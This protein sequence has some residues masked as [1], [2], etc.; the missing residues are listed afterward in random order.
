ML[1]FEMVTAV[2]GTAAVLFVPAGVSAQTTDRPLTAAEERTVKPGAEFRECAVCPVMVVVP[3]GAFEI[4]SPETEA[5]RDSDEGPRQRITIAKPFAVAKFEATFAEWDACAAGRGCGTWRPRDQAWGRGDQP[6][7]T[8]SWDDAKAYAAW[9]S[10]VTGKSYRLPSEAEWEYA[11]RAGTTTAYAFGPVL[12]SG[13]ANFDASTAGKGGEFRQRTVPVGSFAPNAFGLHD[14]HGN[15][16]EWIEDCW[17]RRYTEMPE[18]TK[19]TGAPWAEEGCEFRVYRGGSWSD[20]MDVLRS[21]NRG[22]Y[23]PF[24]RNVGSGFRVARSLDR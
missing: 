1:R 20:A 14:M 16:W 18:A 23:E 8:V 15:A 22:R 3:A 9:I 12:G 2:L 4:G 6:V 10:G 21:A 19:A 11:A 24:I 17:H 13:Q 5:G 7:I